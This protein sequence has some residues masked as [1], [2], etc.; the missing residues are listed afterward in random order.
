MMLLTFEMMSIEMTSTHDNQLP[1]WGVGEDK[2]GHEDHKSPSTK[3]V[4]ESRQGAYLPQTVPG[5]IGWSL[6]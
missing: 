2:G 5:Q 4:E 1:L 6:V 3:A